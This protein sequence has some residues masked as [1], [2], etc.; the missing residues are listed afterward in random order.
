MTNAK[1]FAKYLFVGI[2]LMCGLLFAK[3]RFMWSVNMDVM[4]DQIL[5]FA[6]SQGFFAQWQITANKDGSFRPGDT[7]VTQYNGGVL[8]KF[9]LS[10][11]GMVCA[12][13]RC[14]WDSSEPLDPTPIIV[15]GKVSN[16]GATPTFI[17]TTGR[18]NGIPISIATPIGQIFHDD[19][20]RW[21]IRAG[22]DPSDGSWAGQDPGAG[23]GGGGGGLIHV[24]E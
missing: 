16:I 1:A 24:P 2:A 23:S 18:D 12:F 13:G 10:T 4:D 21:T 8:A 11:R 6:K 3:E 19:N 7:I 9:T 14:I 22:G 20:R 17:Y 15:Q 5:D